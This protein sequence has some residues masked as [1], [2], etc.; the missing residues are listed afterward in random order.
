MERGWFEWSR[1]D[2]A[3]LGIYAH[4]LMV[5]SREIF[6]G[7]LGPERPGRDQ[8][9]ERLT[10]LNRLLGRG[11][12]ECVE[13]EEGAL[14]W[15]LGGVGYCFWAEPRF[16]RM[17]KMIEEGRGGFYVPPSG[18]GWLDGVVL[19]TG[20]NG[21]DMFV[22]KRGIFGEPSFLS[23]TDVMIDRRVIPAGSLWN[24][25]IKRRETLV[26]D[27]LRRQDLPVG[28]VLPWARVESLRPLRITPWSMK[29]GEA[30]KR[31]FGGVDEWG[32]VVGV[33]LDWIDGVLGLCER[34][35]VGLVERVNERVRQQWRRLRLLID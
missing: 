21:V 17:F 15:K 5:V 25:K 31:A 1:K 2:E 12:G 7:V 26:G 16:L 13:V 33:D 29:D 32:R 35:K 6:E 28:V 27:R 22:G 3:N 30:R 18:L 11:N 34:K 23:L 14:N 19:V 24:I 8:W 20:R 9:L 4:E 10:Q